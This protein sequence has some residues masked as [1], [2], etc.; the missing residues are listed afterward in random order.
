MTAL[1]KPLSNVQLE[2][3]KIYSTD[4]TDEEVLEVKRLLAQHFAKKTI[5]AAEKVWHEKG[6]TNDIMDEWLNDE[7]Q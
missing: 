7:N 6:L 1:Q 4:I 3:L 5:D 2:L